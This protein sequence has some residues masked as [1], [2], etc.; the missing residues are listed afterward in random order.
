MKSE[1]QNNIISK[2]RKLRE[3]HKYSQ[4]DIAILLGLSNGHIGNI[5]SL[6]SNHKY[7][8]NQILKIC[9]EFNFPIEHIFLSDEDYTAN[10]DIVSNVVGKIVQYEE[11]KENY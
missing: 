7:T 2:I 8:L 4:E 9:K 3:E 11:Q 1:Y 5:E 6:K 10:L